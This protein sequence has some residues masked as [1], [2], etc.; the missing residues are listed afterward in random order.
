MDKIDFGKLAVDN[1]STEEI[2]KWLHNASK[3]Q[4]AAMLEA[5]E[6]GNIGL[7][8]GSISQLSI[9]AGVIRALDE[10]VNGKKEKVV[11]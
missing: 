5:L 8:G 9:V 3:K 4:L 7:I 6:N 11:L 1:Y 2:I 10:K